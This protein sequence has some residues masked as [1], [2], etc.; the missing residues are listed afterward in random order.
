M[1]M[2]QRKITYNL[3]SRSQ[4]ISYIKTGIDLKL[5]KLLEYYSIPLMN[6]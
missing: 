3:K 1:Q 5:K 2:Q 6:I 4:V